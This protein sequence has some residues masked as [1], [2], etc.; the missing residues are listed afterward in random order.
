[1][2]HSHA[3]ILNY[4][5]PPPKNKDFF[6][7]I[8]PDPHATTEEVA[9]GFV[10]YLSRHVLPGVSFI[11]V[12]PHDPIPKANVTLFLVHAVNQKLEGM[13]DHHTFQ[14]IGMNL[15]LEGKKY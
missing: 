13:Y 3:A 10:E 5:N 7:N 15:L 14:R 6:V 2:A 8:I 11:N 1:M 12:K 4:I 9:A